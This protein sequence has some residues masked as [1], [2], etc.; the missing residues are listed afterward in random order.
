MD[1]YLFKK[2]FRQHCLRVCQ[3]CPRKAH[4]L[5]RKYKLQKIDNLEHNN[6]MS[7][8]EHKTFGERD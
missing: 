3:N 7:N 5:V 4:T 6:R 1:I 8:I 2:Y